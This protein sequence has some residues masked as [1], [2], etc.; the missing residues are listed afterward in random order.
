MKVFIIPDIHLKPWILDKADML[1]KRGD[2]DK[3]I[4]LG[5]F[6][7]DWGKQYNIGLYEETLNRLEKFLKEYNNSI[8]CYGN[9][10]ISYIWQASQSGYSSL[11]RDTVVLHLD[12]IKKVL[13]EE[14]YG[15]IHKIDNVLFSHAGLCRSFVLENFGT[16]GSIGIDDIVSDINKMG[17]DKLWKDNSP[18]WA[19]PQGGRYPL[20][21]GGLMQVVGHTPVKCTSYEEEYDLLTMDNFSTYNTLD[22]KPIGDQ[23]FVCVDT[24]TK[25]WHYI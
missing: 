20:Y 14:N 21:S 7:D 6:V 3:I 1:V 23:K 11:A 19:R 16:K 4:F 2:Y 22:R 25:E 18:I 24:V 17:R 10:D 9:H 12:K 8:I 5:D 15:F 13:P